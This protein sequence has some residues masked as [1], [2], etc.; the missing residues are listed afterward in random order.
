LARGLSYYTG[1]IFEAKANA[2]TFTPS[3]LGGGRYD[4]LTGI[5]GLKD[6]SGVGI[7]F[8]IDRIYDVME[9][10]NLFPNSVE[11]ISTTKI[12]LANFGE[13][14]LLHCLQLV[15]KL[16]AHGINA[17][18]YPDVV[19]KIAKQFEYA[20]KKQIPFVAVVGSNEIASN[21]VMLKNMSS[22]NQEEVNFEKLLTIL[23]NN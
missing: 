8:G 23:Q 12:L 16:R 14:E 10:L 6:L 21:T 22:G 11:K 15:S 13:N 5:F 18:V 2:G 1:T 9:E 19:K 4:D 20:D 17:E 3:I 7:S